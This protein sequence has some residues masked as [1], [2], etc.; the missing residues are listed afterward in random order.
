MENEIGSGLVV[1]SIGGLYTVRDKNGKNTECRAKGSFRKAGT[2]PLAGDYVSYKLQSDGTGFITE[3]MPRKNALIRPAAA[4]VDLLVIV[5]AAASP[6]P[7]LFVLDKLTAVAAVNKIEVLIAVN[8]TDIQSA[9]YLED[10]YLRAGIKTLAVC[11]SNPDACAD[12]LGA[13][14]NAMAKKITF[15]TGASGVGKSS[16]INA[17]Y[18]DLSL[19]TG[20]ISRKISRGKHTT[21]CTELFCVANDTYIADTPGFTS[22]D[23][24]G[25]GMLSSETLLGAFPDIERYAENCRYKKCTHVCEDG[26]GVI[27][28]LEEGKISRSRHESYKT[29]FGELKEIKPWESQ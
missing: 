27:R 7:D 11:A 20:E 10:I 2:S 25:F 17:L 3:I 22:F 23:V 24:A 26:C 8:K 18:P 16:L 15:F 19:S 29:L 21:R 14:R 5:A 9:D 4:N 13:I 28:A 1:K 12:S 6:N